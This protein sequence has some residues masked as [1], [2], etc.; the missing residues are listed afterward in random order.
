MKFTTYDSSGNLPEDVRKQIFEEL[1]QMANDFNCKTITATIVEF[2]CRENGYRCVVDT[3]ST[4]HG[5]MYLSAS[6]GA[7]PDRHS[8]GDVGT[9]KYFST[10]SRG[11]WAWV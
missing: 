2:P 3:N 7:S 1:E 8:V 4:L 5:R 9:V 6:A 11:W 10:A